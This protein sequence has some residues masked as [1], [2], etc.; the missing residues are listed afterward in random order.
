MIGSVLKRYT[1][2]VC[3]KCN[4]S[5]DHMLVSLGG[6]HHHVTQIQFLTEKKI[7]FLFLLPFS[8]QIPWF[9]MSEMSWLK[10]SSH[11][12]LK[13]R[14]L[15]RASFHVVPFILKSP[16]NKRQR[17]L[18]ILQLLPNLQKWCDFW[19]FP[20]RKCATVGHWKNKQQ[21]TFCFNNFSLLHLYELGLPYKVLYCI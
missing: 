15:C 13:P 3:I 10:G 16:G 8:N 12:E 5:T 21:G 20:S 18:D 1:K 2:D 4:I 11:I 17:W 9:P 7:L 14:L 19:H 6:L